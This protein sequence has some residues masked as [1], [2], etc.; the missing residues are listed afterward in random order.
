[1]QPGLVSTTETSPGVLADGGTALVRLFVFTRPVPQQAPP[2]LASLLEPERRRDGTV[3]DWHFS[4]DATPADRERLRAWRSSYV[5]ERLIGD[6]ATVRAFIDWAD[7]H[8]DVSALHGLRL[9][10]A[11][12]SP[13]SVMRVARQASEAA[14]LCRRLGENG[15][16]L[17]GGERLGLI[18][19]FVTSLGPVNVLTDRHASVIAG[20]DSLTVYDNIAGKFNVSGWREDERGL[21]ATTPDGEVAL[22]NGHA[23]HLLQ[24]MAPGYES[25]TVHPVPLTRIF[26]EL[27]GFLPEMAQEAANSHTEL[28]AHTSFKPWR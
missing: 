11:H 17:L 1:M 8:C 27:I 13:H 7:R 14:D 19:G 3:V 6:V 26:A 4:A 23:A 25:V 5:T 21:V 28:L 16:G 24:K 20:V 15:L 10:E 18:R 9:A 22:G 2:Q 12:F